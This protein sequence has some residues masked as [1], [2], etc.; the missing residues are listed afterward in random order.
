M[1]KKIGVK[2]SIDHFGRESINLNYIERLPLDAVKIDGGIIKDV[3]HDVHK[4]NVVSA[5]LSMSKKLG[6]E[7][8]ANHVDSEEIKQLLEEMGCDFAQGYHFGKAV[9]A[10][11]ISDVIKNNA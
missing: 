2:L 7:V 3:I 9:P 4:E 1:L 10:F 6:L 11:E 8:G 5:I